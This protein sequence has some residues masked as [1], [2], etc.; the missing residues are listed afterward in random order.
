[1]ASINDRKRANAIPSL[2]DRLST[3]RAGDA[4]GAT[5]ASGEMPDLDI[6]SAL[7]RDLGWLLNSTSLSSTTDLAS[8][9][10]VSRSVLNYGIANFSGRSVGNADSFEIAQSLK[11][12]IARYEPRLRPASLLIQVST[13][14]AD[15]DQRQIRIRI[16]GEY[17]AQNQWL[18]LA[19][20]LCLDTESGRLEVID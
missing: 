12:A 3:R 4:S 16:E 17:A 14:G 15:H 20:D 10:N 1:M 11:K 9:P 19:M 8:W 5:A 18:P 6:K 13:E 7:L 2:L